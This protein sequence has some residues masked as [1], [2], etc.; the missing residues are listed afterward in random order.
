M[1]LSQPETEAQYVS[2]LLRYSLSL[3]AHSC[4][5]PGH[6]ELFDTMAAVAQGK[7][8]EEL[9]PLSQTEQM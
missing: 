4:L 7:T 8:M 6:L 5:S 1:C 9:G 2:K 3:G